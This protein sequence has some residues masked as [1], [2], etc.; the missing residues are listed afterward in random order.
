MSIPPGP[1][2][3]SILAV[4]LLL[5]VP[6]ALFRRQQGQSVGHRWLV[7]GFTTAAVAFVSS[8]FHFGF[9]FGAELGDGVGEGYYR[10]LPL[11][12]VEAAI[13]GVFLVLLWLE[14]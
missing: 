2:F 3:G 12:G 6:V 10:A 11:L 1:G 7:L 8:A 13:V 9:V 4:V 14:Q 5:A